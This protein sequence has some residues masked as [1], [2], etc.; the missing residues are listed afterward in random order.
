M[1]VDSSTYTRKLQCCKSKPNVRGPE[2]PQGPAGESGVGILNMLYFKDIQV[3]TPGG[4]GAIKT[5]DLSYNNALTGS[6]GLNDFFTENTNEDTNI[7]FSRLTNPTSYGIEIYAHCDLSGSKSDD[8]IIL[9]LSGTSIE[10]GFNN[11]L[12]IDARTVNLKNGD[13]ITTS[14]S[15]GPIMYRITNSNASPS[16]LVIHTNNKYRFRVTIKANNETVSLAN[17]QLVIKAIK[18][19]IT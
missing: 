15:F 10:P 9:D 16:T 4:A 3:E 12:Q 5:E 17:T 6:A 2:G 19:G 11:I 1:P 18:T 7:I 14:V 8:A 13:G